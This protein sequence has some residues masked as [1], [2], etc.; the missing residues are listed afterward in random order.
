MER[1]MIREVPALPPDIRLVPALVLGAAD[2]HFVDRVLPQ[3]VRQG[4]EVLR[5]H[6]S[7]RAANPARPAAP[8]VVVR[9]DVRGAAGPARLRRA[10]P[11]DALGCP[12]LR[13]W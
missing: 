8:G 11:G 2:L 6:A 10:L 5:R 3:H 12:S 9:K 4:P 13:P 1:G 7:A